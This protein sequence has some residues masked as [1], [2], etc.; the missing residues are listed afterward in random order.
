MRLWTIHPQYLDAR[1]LVALWR[2]ALLAQQ[3]LRGIT[4][5][6][7]HHPQLARFRAS[8][9]PLAAIASYL[10]GIFEEAQQRGYCFDS[11]KIPLLRASEPMEETKGQLLYEWRHLQQKLKVREFARYRH[12]RSLKAPIPHPLFRIVAGEVQT[13]ERVRKYAS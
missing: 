1:G 3:V 13:W 8:A 6:Y 12:C 11:R 5:G 9:D 2:E 7:R 4:K 10:G